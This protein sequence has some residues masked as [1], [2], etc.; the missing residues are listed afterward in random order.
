MLL[1]SLEAVVAE[2][3]TACRTHSRTEQTV[4]YLRFCHTAAV[5]VYPAAPGLVAAVALETEM[6]AIMEQHSA[7][8][9]HLLVAS[10]ALVALAVELAVVM[11][12][13]AVEA[14]VTS[15]DKVVMAGLAMEPTMP[16]AD[17]VA[18][19]MSLIR[20]PTCKIAP[21]TVALADMELVAATDTSIFPSIASKYQLVAHK[22][23]VDCTK[24]TTCAVSLYPA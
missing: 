13:V 16:P 22:M 6:P 11:V 1:S 8:G 21:V 12:L 20:L 19:V 23:L 14:A 7:Q 24:L 15:V 4:L 9:V 18:R 17:K 2:T 10:V 3:M 5:M